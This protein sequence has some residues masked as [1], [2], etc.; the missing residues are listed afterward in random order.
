VDALRQQ[1]FDAMFDIAGVAVIDETAG[2]GPK[3]PA[4]A[5]QFA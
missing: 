4:V 1:L 2:Q 3:E 5:F